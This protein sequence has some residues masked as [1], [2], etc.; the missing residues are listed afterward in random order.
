M[1]KKKWISLGIIA[2]G[3]AIVLT[4][5]SLLFEKNTGVALPWWAYIVGRVIY[6]LIVYLI[7]LITKITSQRYETMLS[8]ADFH[9]D[10]HYKW[11]KQI[12]SLD[13]ESKRLANTYLTTK[14]F[15]NFSEITGYRFETYQ[16]GVNVDLPED[17]RFVSLV[18][19][20]RKEGV[21]QE[22][23]YIPVFEVEVDAEVIGDGIT[24]ITSALLEKY[25]ELKDMAELQ[26]DVNKILEINASDEITENAL[27][28]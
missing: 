20:V 23:L 3:A 27:K 6:A 5:F 24:E 17:K 15:V 4:V 21:E 22:F 9:A 10:R 16:S 2:V 25:P 7:Y 13:F 11:N 18:L 1:T 19:S 14:P 12:V 28:E 26:A 8:R